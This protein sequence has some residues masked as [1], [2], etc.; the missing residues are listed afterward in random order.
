MASWVWIVVAAAAAVVVFLVVM[1]ALRTRRTRRLQDRFGPEYDR[2]VETAD[3]RRDAERELRDRERRREH[4]DIRPL[5]PAARDRYAEQWRMTQERFVDKPAESVAAADTLVTAVMRER[6]YPIEDFEQR[7]ADVSV[8]HPNVVENY[9]SALR[10]ARASATGDAT[11]EDL[12]Q[13]MVHYRSLFDELL[14]A[15]DDALSRDTAR[16]EAPADDRVIS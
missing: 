2:T 16:D 5:P 11:T 7:A 12:R 13:A 6:G 15:E 8:D 9:R 4:F 14:G 1:A 3:N 10:I